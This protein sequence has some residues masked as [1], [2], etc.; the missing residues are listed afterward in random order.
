MRTATT[1]VCTRGGKLG[2]YRLHRRLRFRVA[3]C[4]TRVPAIATCACYR[5]T[6]AVLQRR[7]RCLCLR[8]RVARA[9]LFD[10]RAA[11]RCAHLT[12][13]APCACGY[14]SCRCT[15]VYCLPG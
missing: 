13:V 14:L 8:D 7:Q 5:T 1:C 2:G 12:C 3:V 10:E 4:G 15:C 11:L 6:P 9:L